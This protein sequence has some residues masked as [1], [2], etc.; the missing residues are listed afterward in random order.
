VVLSFES[1]DK[2]LKDARAQIFPLSD[3]F[4]TL[5]QLGT[6]HLMPEKQNNWGVTVLILEKKHFENVVF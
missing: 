6:D 2:I 3:F 4:Q 5:L 1:V